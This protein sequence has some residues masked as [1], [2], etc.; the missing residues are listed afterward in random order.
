MGTGVGILNEWGDPHR[1]HLLGEFFRKIML[2]RESKCIVVLSLT[3]HT[4]MSEKKEKDARTN[5]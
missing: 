3:G 2:L 1:P 5:P 4:Y